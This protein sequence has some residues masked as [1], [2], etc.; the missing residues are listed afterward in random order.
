M[1]LQLHHFVAVCFLFIS[2]TNV[3]SQTA[4]DGSALLKR[5]VA[6]ARF[7][8][9]T[10]YGKGLF[11]DK[12]NDPMGKQALDILS[13]R[14]AD[15]QKFILLERSDL[16]KVLEEMR[17][18]GSSSHQNV[19]ADY[20]IVGSITEFGRKNI[21]DVNL[22]SRSKTQI[23]EAAV[24]IRLIDV[25][26]GQIIYSEEARGEAETSSSTVLG[27][28]ER[29]DYDATLSDKAISA[30]I[31]KLVENVVNN[32]FERPWKSFLLSADADAVLIAGGKSQGLKAGDQFHVIE[33]GRTVRNP[34]TGMNIELPGRNVGTITIMTTG[35]DDPMNEYSIVQFVSGAIDAQNLDK[36][37]IQEIRQ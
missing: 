29:A 18:S 1:R 21:G 23:V 20:I 24:S 31:S 36:Y 2:S 26:T 37:I 30:A 22:F 9:E 19:G 14:L 32:C 27:L 8:N 34:Q 6:I 28:G 13:A 10:S 7:S 11:Y 25:S 17:L 3:L 15:S 35:G 12:D 4:T 33:R 5:K 16:G